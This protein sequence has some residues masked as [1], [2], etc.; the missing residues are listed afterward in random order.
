MARC[1]KMVKGKHGDRRCKNQSTHGD[2]CTVHSGKRQRSRSTSRRRRTRSTSRRNRRRTRSNSRRRQQRGRGYF[3]GGATDPADQQS[4]RELSDTIANLKSTVSKLCSEK[5]ENAEDYAALMGEADNLK[6]QTEAL[7]RKLLVKNANRDEVTRSMNNLNADMA[8]LQQQLANLQEQ[9][10]QTLQRK[11]AQIAEA[12]RGI[13][14]LNNALDSFRKQLREEDDKCANALNDIAAKI[15][16][17]QQQ[18]AA[19]RQQ[20]VRASNLQRA[21]EGMSSMDVLQE[22][23]TA[24]SGLP[25]ESPI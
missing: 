11:E 20:V 10:H 7:Y 17:V 2:Y 5:L 13:S 1:K 12:E 8:K 4:M 18:Q 3:W 14:D 23:R 25:R 9:C 19:L 16:S 21:S 24:R 15:T 22:A 6:S